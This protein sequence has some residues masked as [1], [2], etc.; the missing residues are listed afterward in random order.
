MA[1][2]KKTKTRAKAAKRA[3]SGS[4]GRTMATRGRKAA[5]E[6][7]EMLLTE[8]REIYSAENQL[9]KIMPR[10]AKA[11]DSEALHEALNR[12]LEQAEE[13]VTELENAFEEM[14]AS[15]GRVKNVA[16]EGLLRDAMKHIREIP[17]G[18]ALDAALI[19]AVQKLEHYCIAA[20]GT[21]RAFA[22][23]L[24]ESTASRLMERVLGEGKD[25]DSELT[26]LAE[27]EINPA[28]LEMGERAGDGGRMGRGGG[29][30]RA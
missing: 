19:G 20:W 24:G 4:R 17:R 21:S 12:R 28:M 9:I 29:E 3:N 27:E 8:L 5:P 15:P 10:L 30:A 25:L 26:E 7:Q 1:A 23:A 22:N 6:P 13:L 16:A 14:G 11:I 2:R 18:P